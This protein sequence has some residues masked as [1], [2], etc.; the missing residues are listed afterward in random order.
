MSTA[1][2]R[3]G[4]DTHLRIRGPLPF[5]VA[6]SILPAIGALYPNTQMTQADGDDVLHL[7]IP[8]R[9]RP[10]AEGLGEGI[11]PVEVVRID[12]Q[13]IKFATVEEVGEFLVTIME[14]A[15]AAQAPEN[16]LQWSYEVPRGRG[17]ARYVLIVA[18]SREQ[19]PHE[20]QQA[21]EARANAA[22]AKL[23]AVKAK[24]ASHSRTKLASEL[25]A[26]LEDPGTTP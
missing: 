2:E 11:E 16:Y 7:V 23:A 10:V 14:N 24:V 25:R 21:A 9:D 1:N 26:I 5:D 20:L 15:L 4:T 18:R 6:G 17:H 12:P 13:G 3:E 22:E 8:A 19:T